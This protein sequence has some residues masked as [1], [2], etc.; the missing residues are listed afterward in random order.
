M[1][2]RSMPDPTEEPRWHVIL[3]RSG[4]LLHNS[5]GDAIVFP[6]RAEAK[7]WKMAE[8]RVRRYY[9][10]VRWGVPARLG[11]LAPSAHPA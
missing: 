6:N 11:T 8:D 5:Q 1:L 2:S 3:T 7:N 4:K 9:G 10:P